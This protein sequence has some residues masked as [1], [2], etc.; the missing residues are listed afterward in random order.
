[1]KYALAYMKTESSPSTHK[2]VVEGDPLLRHLAKKMR[3]ARKR[4]GLTQQEL[5]RLARLTRLRIIEIE[6]GS[7]A[8]AMGAYAKAAHAMGF[9]MGLDAYQRPVFEELDGLFK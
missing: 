7:P 6:R 1:M 5:A 8:V 9:Q 4:R 2:S 3:E